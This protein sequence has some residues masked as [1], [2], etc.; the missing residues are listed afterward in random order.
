VLSPEV[1]KSI[2]QLAGSNILKLPKFVLDVGDMIILKVWATGPKEQIQGVA[3]IVPG[4]N[5]IPFS[6]LRTS[7]KLIL[8]A[9]LARLL[10]I[11]VIIQGL[12]LLS[13]LFL[14]LQL[15]VQAIVAIDLIVFLLFIAIYI[16]LDRKTM[17]SLLK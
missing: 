16:F 8:V 1:T 15:D 17:I 3:K 12:R 13:P 9:I 5:F 2:P 14:A 4:G 11:A 7:W 6:D 10:I